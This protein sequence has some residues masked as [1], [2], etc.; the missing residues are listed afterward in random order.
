LKITGDK[1]AERTGKALRNVIKGPQVFTLTP[2]NH[3]WPQQLEARLDHD[4][5]SRLWCI[6]NVDILTQPCVGLFCSVRCP[7]S[8]IIAAHDAA[9]KLREDGTTVV[10]GFQSPVEKECLRILLG[11]HQPVVICL[12]RALAKI[13]LPADWR[14]ALD[15]GRLLILSPFEKRP[16]RPTVDSA[17]QR[18]R[19]VAA[20]SDEVLVIH[21]ER[22]GNI[23]RISELVD[24]WGIPQRSLM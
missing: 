14:K 19:L 2:S 11:G 1:T 23:E 12:A 20:L 18:N 9:S 6:G 24:R 3:S 16:S 8:A 15:T 5:P 13:R 7:G 22:G 17:R 10:S 21:A 4:A